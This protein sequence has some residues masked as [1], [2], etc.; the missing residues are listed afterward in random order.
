[1]T[2]SL[3]S[4]FLLQWII[5]EQAC[6]MYSVVVVPLYDTLG[7]D[8]CVYIINQGMSMTPPAP[9]LPPPPPPLLHLLHPGTSVYK[10]RERGQI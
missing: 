4:Y 8:A 10:I 5:S 7:S 2:K 3:H 9:A 6:S 1:M